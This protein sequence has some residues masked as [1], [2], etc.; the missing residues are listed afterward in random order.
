MLYALKL[1]LCGV[2]NVVVSERKATVRLGLVAGG[3]KAG[4]SSDLWTSSKSGS[5]CRY[6]NVRGAVFE[7]L[8]SSKGSSV[9][10]RMGCGE[11]AL[12]SSN[13]FLGPNVFQKQIS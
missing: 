9:S 3:C 2:V 11:N 12:A 7:V 8:V 1:G 10:R 6:E 5:T 13:I 4:S